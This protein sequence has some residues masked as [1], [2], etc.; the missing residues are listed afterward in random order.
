MGLLG[1][2]AM[3]IWHDVMAHAEADY[4]EWHSKEHMRERVGVPGFRRGHRY[5]AIAGAPRYLNLYEVDD[6]AVLTSKPYLE[7]LD[8]P[9]P[10]SQRALPSMRHN[11]RT[12]CRVDASFGG[13]GICAY[14]LTIQL[15]AAG[16]DD[17]LRG[18]L[19]TAALPPLPGKPGIIGAHLLQG[20]HAASRT[21]T[22]EKRLRGTPDAIADWVVLVAGYDGDALQAVR[23]G[24][25]ADRELQ[26]HGASGPPIAGIYRLLHTITEPDLGA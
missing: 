1:R 25:L 6:V 18:W 16:R 21:E 3:V 12:L 13:G 11:N 22:E 23:A 24:Q 10:W 7:R 2:G 9:T 20:D 8:H 14:L 15:A 17:E 26:A 5:V 4:N 19:T